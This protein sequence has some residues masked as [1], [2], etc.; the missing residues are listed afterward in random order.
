MTMTREETTE[1]TKQVAIK[2]TDDD[3]RIATGVVLTPNE[4]DHQGDFLRPEGIRALY[5]DSPDNGVMHAYFPN[6]S[7][8]LVRNEVL[9][10]DKRIDGV[11]FEAGEWVI[12]R[13]YHDDRL[14]KLVKDDVLG[15]FSIGGEITKY[16][17]YRMLPADVSVPEEVEFEEP[18]TKLIDGTVTEIS[19]VDIPAVPKADHAVVKSMEK[20]IVSDVSGESEF[21]EVMLGRGHS[22]DDARR[23]WAYLKELRMSNE[24]D[25]TDVETEAGDASK[26]LNEEDV[27]VLK[28][29]ANLVR[30]TGADDPAEA[31]EEPAEET[32][33]A[34]TDD[35]ETDNMTEETEKSIPEQN[36][37]AISELTEAVKSIAEDEEEA[38]DAE[39]EAEE[40]EPDLA[41]KNAEAIQELTEAVEEI[42][43]QSGGSTQITDPDPEEDAEK[44]REA[45]KLNFFVPSDRR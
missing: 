20:N 9:D 14:W 42:G 25:N 33:K 43:K 44:S 31:G 8:E 16:Q 28:R 10:Q 11:K 5:S 29:L 36:A 34:E 41:E 13:K 32:E 37:E 15:G 39:K 6:D 23:L 30:K 1:F 3:E 26:E 35:N 38:E 2:A 19:D 17:E 4:V 40:E 24:D 18:A 21:I 27:G 7:A 22:E 12:S 45:E